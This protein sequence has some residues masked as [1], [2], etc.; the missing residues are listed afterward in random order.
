[1]PPPNASAA[2][3]SPSDDDAAG[4]GVAREVLSIYLGAFCCLCTACLSWIPYCCYYKGSAAA[5]LEH[6]DKKVR[7]KRAAQKKEAEKK[8][9]ADKAALAVAPPVV[10]TVPAPIQPSAADDALIDALY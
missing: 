6:E 5:L 8:A 1:M 9:A 3:D 2:D 4:A 7:D 10:S